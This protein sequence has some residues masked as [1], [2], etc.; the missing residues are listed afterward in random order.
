MALTTPEVIRYQ[1]DM[2]AGRAVLHDLTREAIVPKGFAGPLITPAIA[3]EQVL[4]V[5]AENDFTLFE[6]F[7]TDI[8][9]HSQNRERAEEVLRSLDTFL[10]GLLAGLDE[11]TLFI[12][13]SDHG[14]IEDLGT[15]GH[16]FNNVPLVALGPAAGQILAGSTSL[17]DVMP[18][19][20]RVICPE[21]VTL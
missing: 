2:L 1:K 15:R 11:D 6:Y 9:G 7:L 21:G 10:T 16:T 8:A 12:L 5:A 13:T 4:A 3:A 18:R 19:V 14:N 17:M 20:L